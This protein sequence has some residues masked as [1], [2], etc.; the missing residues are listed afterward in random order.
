MTDYSLRT[1]P[2]LSVADLRKMYEQEQVRDVLVDSSEVTFDAAG[3]G[4]VRFKPKEGGSSKEVEVALD[5]ALNHFA[6]WLGVPAPFISRQDADVQDTILN[7][8]MGRKPGDFVVGVGKSGTIQEIRSP[9]ME[10]IDPRAVIDVAAR[11]VGDDAQVIDGWRDATEYRFDVV[12]RDGS[13]YA[14]G[15]DPKVNDITKGGLRF[16]QDTKHRLA[17][18]VAPFLFRLVCT[19]GMEHP[20]VGSP[21]SLRQS[22]SEAMGELEL[23]ARLAFDRVET[24]IAAFYDL[25]NK[26]VGDAEQMLIRLQRERGFSSS[27]LTKMLERVPALVEDPA[28]A[29]LFDVVNVVTNIANL[30]GT[31]EKPNARRKLEQAGGFVISDHAARCPRCQS[32][33]GGH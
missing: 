4:V 1:I 3:S 30:P 10:R 31:V 23:A 33:L 26:K 17:P 9:G 27:A 16:G 28:D 19:N 22:I 11:V 2:D 14:I 32:A 6:G 24:E 13:D 25:R 21:V 5:G 12:V 18:W 20:Q 8:L 15:G 7:L 29:T